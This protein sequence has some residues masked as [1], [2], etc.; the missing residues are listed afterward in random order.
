MYPS[1]LIP[2][3]KMENN[4]GIRLLHE[5]VG[6]KIRIMSDDYHEIP[7]GMDVNNTYHKIVFQI[8]EE[9]PDSFAFGVLFTLSLSSFASSAPR[10]ISEINFIAGE[11]WNIDYF[12]NGLEFKN[13]RL[14]FSA[15]YVSGRLMKTDI[16]FESGGRVTLVTRNRG[17][18][19]DRWLKNLEGKKHIQ[20]VK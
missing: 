8:E 3:I 13:K 16:D 1:G 5:T 2:R 4:V 10:G 14:C 11:D 18:S 7:T 6:I 17:K 15:D 20:R 19:A 12:M 9:E